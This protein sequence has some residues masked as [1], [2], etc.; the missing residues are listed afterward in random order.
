MKMRLV[1]LGL[2]AVVVWPMVSGCETKPYDYTN[3][4]AYPP[5]S[6]LVL[7][8]LNESTDVAGTYSYLSTVTYPVAEMGYY[9][10]PVAVVDHFFKENGMPTPGEMH[11]APLNKIREIIG[12][13]A[14]LYITLKQYGTKYEVITSMTTVCAQAKLVDTKTGTLLWEGTV[15]AQ[16]NSGGSGSILADVIAAALEQVISKSTDHA[17]DV[18]RVANAQ[19]AIKDHGLLYGPYHPK[20]ATAK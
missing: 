10:F 5:R 19:F 3:Y 16:Q 15:A 13:D 12:A 8:P 2:C 11:Q 14:V 6:I 17:H 4:R 1:N 18:S 20:Y 7:P 9:I